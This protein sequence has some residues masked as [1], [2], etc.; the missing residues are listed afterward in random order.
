MVKYINAKGL[1]FYLF[2]KSLYSIPRGDR[3]AGI[4]LTAMASPEA[5]ARPR[6]TS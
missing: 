4:G 1:D 6:I 3:T 2:G 5:V